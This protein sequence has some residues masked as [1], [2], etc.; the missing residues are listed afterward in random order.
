MKADIHRYVPG[1]S[2]VGSSRDILCFG[3]EIKSRKSLFALHSYRLAL[4][5][6]PPTAAFSLLQESM[7]HLPMG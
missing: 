2:T 7:T 1:V 5:A 6:C 3:W 4:P